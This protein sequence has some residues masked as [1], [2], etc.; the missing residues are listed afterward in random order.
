MLHHL[1]KK[2]KTTIQNEPWRRLRSCEI[3]ELH[4]DSH[5]ESAG[6]KHYTLAWKQ[7]LD[8]LLAF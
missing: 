1:L 6:R 7:D 8:F 5:K 3:C 4:A 2:Q